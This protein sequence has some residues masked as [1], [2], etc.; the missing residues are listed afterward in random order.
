VWLQ[1]GHLAVEDYRQKPVQLINRLRYQ[2]QVSGRA[3]EIAEVLSALATKP[4][5]VATV[6]ESS[7]AAT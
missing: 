4:A 1:R 3:A 2:G 6:D 5:L 7:S